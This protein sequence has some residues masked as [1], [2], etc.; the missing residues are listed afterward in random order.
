MEV[1]GQLHILATL[2]PLDRRLGGPQGRSGRCE[3]KNLATFGNRT[4]AVQPVARRYT[5]TSQ[6]RWY[7]SEKG[8]F[9]VSYV[10]L[11][12]LHS[13]AGTLQVS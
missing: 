6:L 7:V 8:V 4:L 11:W 5:F 13:P 9:S 12:E 3:E 10:I 1:S 2:L